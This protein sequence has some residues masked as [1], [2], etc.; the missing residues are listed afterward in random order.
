MSSYNTKNAGVRR[1]LQ[2]A[3]DMTIEPDFH[4]APL[5]E[6]LF[7]WHFTLRGPPGTDF[8]GGR[9]HG[10]IFL[11]AQY[12]FAPPTFRFSHESGRFEVNKAICLS[13]SEHHA[14]LWRPAWGVRT[15]LLGLVGFFPSPADGAI[16]GMD[17]KPADR[18]QIALISRD[19]CCPQCGVKNIDLL[20]DNV[21]VSQTADQEENVNGLKFGYESDKSKTTTTNDPSTNETNSPSTNTSIEASLS[22]PEIVVEP[23]RLPTSYKIDGLI[24]ICIMILVALVLKRLV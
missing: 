9:Y 4:A 21:E 23:N 15:A 16:G 3:K 2:E 8:E 14:E 24:T 13:I 1:I 17:L 5:D 6:N 20:P 7:E 19:Y 22:D 12:P 18:K 11:P 10:R